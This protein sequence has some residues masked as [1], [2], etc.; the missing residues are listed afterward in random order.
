[1]SDTMAQIAAQIAQERTSPVIVHPSDPRAHQRPWWRQGA[2]PVDN[3]FQSLGDKYCLYCKDLTDHDEE[4]GYADGVYVSRQRCNR[5][6]R[7]SGF[8]I[9]NAALITHDRPLPTVAL[10]WCNTRGPDRR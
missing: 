9:M 4:A 5:C 3:P 2:L 8:A 1:M 6:G 7:P 10:Q